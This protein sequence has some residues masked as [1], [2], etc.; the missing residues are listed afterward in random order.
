MST[1]T[2]SKVRSHLLALH[3]AM[4]DSERRDYEKELY[5][6]ADG[7]FLDALIKDP[8]FA[9]LGALTALIVRLDEM[10]E[11]GLSQPG[12]E[13]EFIQRTRALLT[14]ESGDSEFHR[15]YSGLLQKS[16]EV[17]VAHGAV[18][19]ALKSPEGLRTAYLCRNCF[20][21]FES[22][23]STGAETSTSTA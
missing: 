3:R 6:M 1:A 9:W 8:R 22:E 12:L 15:K 5:R 21:I 20:F 10:E 18:M 17:L 7:E 4:V 11:E 16:P 19:R 13:K 2:L 14:P 23:L